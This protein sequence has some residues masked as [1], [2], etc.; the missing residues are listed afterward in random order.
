MS[1]V[2]FQMSGF[3]ILEL[4]ISIA[5]IALLSVGVGVELIAYQRTVAL[6]AAS[7]DIVSE[8]RTAQN[9][10]L[11]GEDGTVPPDGAGDAWG[12]RFSNRTPSTYAKFYGSTFSWANVTATTTLPSSV[13]FT[14]PSLN[15]DKDIIFTKITGTTTPSSITLQTQDGSQ[16]QTITV[17]TSSISVQ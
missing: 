2:A 13:A 16:S 8:L 4:I 12:I 14:D 5:I 11:S 10:A 7:K 9:K 15:T 3:T 1:N 17:A 6:E